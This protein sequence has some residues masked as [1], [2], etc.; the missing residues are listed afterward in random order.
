MTIVTM[1]DD[2]IPPPPAAATGP[3][4][5]CANPPLVVES[6]T[7]GVIPAD[8]SGDDDD[9][10]NTSSGMEDSNG[11]MV[12]METTFEDSAGYFDEE[13]T[14]TEYDEEEIVEEDEEMVEE[15]IESEHASE[16]DLVEVEVVEG[17]EHSAKLENISEEVVEEGTENSEKTA[18]GPTTLVGESPGQSTAASDLNQGSLSAPDPML[19]VPVDLK[20]ERSSSASQGTTGPRSAPSAE[21]DSGPSSQLQQSIS[22]ASGEFQPEDAV[23]QQTQLHQSSSALQQSGSS[24]RHELQGSALS[25]DNEPLNGSAKDVN[26]PAEVLPAA[27]SESDAFFEAD[28]PASKEDAS[29]DEI[30]VHEAVADVVASPVV[31][32]ISHPRPSLESQG[33]VASSLMVGSTISL[34]DREDD[35][36]EQPTRGSKPEHPVTGDVYRPPPPV[37]ARSTWQEDEDP[38]DEGGG[39]MDEIATVAS[40]SPMVPT[41]PEGDE[42]AASSNHPNAEQDPMADLSEASKHSSSSAPIVAKATE[43]SECEGWNPDELWSAP[44]P[45]VED[46][47]A[48][49]VSD[50][51]EE[52]EREGSS[53]G[54]MWTV[55]PPAVE[56][57]LTAAESSEHLIAESGDSPYSH[58]E[59]V[60]MPDEQP[61]YHVDDRTKSIHASACGTRHIGAFTG[62]AVV[63]ASEEEVE[64]EEGSARNDVEAAMEK[65]PDVMK[66][67]DVDRETSTEEAPRRKLKMADIMLILCIFVVFLVLVITLPVVL[68]KQNTN[69]DLP[70]PSVRSIWDSFWIDQDKT[71]TT[72]CSSCRCTA[73]NSSSQFSNAVT[74]RIHACGRPLSGCQEFA[75]W[76]CCVLARRRG[77]CGTA[78]HSSWH[79]LH[80]P[81][82]I[83]R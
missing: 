81:A 76:S 20:N 44:V 59:F 38:T 71:L 67:F 61:Q 22:S 82:F 23:D 74:A 24:L 21:K 58:K 29:E 12:E 3:D 8:T 47:P 56:D 68:T 57:E 40:A 77:S 16:H 36:P 10:Y 80:L 83:H 43:A 26:Q 63:D 42:L 7:T 55:P 34:D 52:F 9:L 15:V 49:V 78:W 79:H 32:P 73:N 19:E 39:R 64:E 37:I 53:S 11:E 62:A 66:R 2:P 41:I 13:V 60:T 30:M 31:S 25:L 72:I 14:E 4:E 18:E 54:Y 50:P 51:T 75:T 6:L 48:P 17:T 35:A 69:R 27:S 70:T 45:A 33:M 65:S 46:E 5:G 28:S 1:A